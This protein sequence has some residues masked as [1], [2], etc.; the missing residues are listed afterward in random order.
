MRKLLFLLLFSLSFAAHCEPDNVSAGELALLPDYC[1]AKGWGERYGYANGPSASQ[2]AYWLSR[3]GPSWKGLHHYCWGLVNVRR[4]QAAG[5]PASVRKHLVATALDDYEYVLRNSTSDFVLLPEIYLRVAEAH[6]ILNNQVAANA[7]Y[8][9]SRELKPD[10]W[11][12]YLQDAQLLV[13]LG[14]NTE[15][16][17]LLAEG[18]SQVPGNRQ[19]QDL[20]RKLGGDPKAIVPMAAASA[21]DTAASMPPDEVRQPSSSPSD[22]APAASTPSQ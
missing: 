2:T 15:A 22:A 1:R 21:P 7:A 17:R 13:K 20:Y 18:L 19:M 14:L 5:V 16:K 9:R 10:Y 4:A 8:R 12:A 3:L 11:P 6:T